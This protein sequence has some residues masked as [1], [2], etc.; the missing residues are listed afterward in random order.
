M[1]L[2]LENKRLSSVSGNYNDN[3]AREMNEV[4]DNFLLDYHDS[5]KVMESL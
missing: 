5:H 4:T 3:G 2:Y 1:L